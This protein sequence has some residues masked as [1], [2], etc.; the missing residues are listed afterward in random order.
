MNKKVEKSQKDL[1]NI[2]LK[3]EEIKREQQEFKRLLN[4]EITL[5]EYIGLNKWEQADL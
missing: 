5:F 1:Y 3:E 4:K 2:K